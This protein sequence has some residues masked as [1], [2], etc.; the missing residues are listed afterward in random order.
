MLFSNV[1]QC[2]QEEQADMLDDAGYA[3]TI[4]G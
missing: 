2:A 4:R 1:Q 3:G